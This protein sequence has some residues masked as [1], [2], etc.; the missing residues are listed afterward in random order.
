M[1]KPLSS[2]SLRNVATVTAS[3]YLGQGAI[4]PVLPQIALDFRLSV[5]TAGLVF[6]SF[7]MARLFLN[8]P[9]GFLSDRYGRRRLMIAGPLL[10]GLG[11]IGSACPARSFLSWRCGSSEGQD[12]PCI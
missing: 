10:A 8:V 9:F 4:A 1:D 6:S 5:V 3:V 2:R 7:A 12:L 11:L